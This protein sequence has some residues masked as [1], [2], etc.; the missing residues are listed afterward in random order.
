MDFDNQKF[1][2][3]DL[4]RLDDVLPEQLF[5]IPLKSRP[6]FPGILTP[7]MISMGR[8]SQIVDKTVGTDS[9]VALLLM[10]D[11]DMEDVHK[12]D[13]YEYGTMAR[14]HKKI[15]LPD[16]GIN[17]L[18]NCL[19]RI[20]V[21]EFLS[22]APSINIQVEYLG[23]KLPK[24]DV[25]IKAL[26]RAILSQLKIL[27]ENNPLF[28][29]EMKLTMVNVD[30]PG[31]IADFVASILNL[32][33]KDY[34]YLIEE[35]NVKAR[36]ETV[37]KF[38]EKE[39]DIVE[40]QKR[41][42]GQINEKIE[43]QQ[44]DFFLQEQLKAIRKELGLDEREKNSEVRRLK[45]KLESLDLTEEARERVN[46]ELE[47]L[48]YLE[49]QASDYAVIRN[50]L[51]IVAQL[52]W[53]Q[54]T[55][56]IRDINYAE[57]VLNK[58]HYGLDDVKQRILEFLA[59][60]ILKEDAQGSIICLVGPPGVGKTSLGKSMARALGRE[61][62]RLS[63]GGMRDEAEIKGHRRTYVGA[64]PGKI[65]QGLKLAQSDNPVFMMDEIDK[66]GVSFQ[67]DPASAL[68]EVLD[69]E[70]NSQFRDN[71]LDLSFDISKILFI[72]TAN[73]LDTIPSVLLDRME[74][75][76]LPGYLDDEKYEIFR[77]YLLPKQLKKHALKKQDLKLSKSI[78]MYII[79]RYAR[80]AGLRNLERQVEKLCRHRA[81][82]KV[83]QSD[84][85]KEIKA[86]DLFALL[87]PERF[88]EDKAPHKKV[89][90]L[91]TGLAWTQYG[92]ATLNIEA[93][94]LN[95]EKPLISLTGQL[96]EVMKES[97]N[98]A[99][100]YVQ[101]ICEQ[102][103]G[104]RGFFDKKNI[105]LHIPAGATPKDGPSAGIT[106]ALALLSLATKEAVPR[107]IAMTGELTL[108]GEIFPIGGLK[109]K[110]LAA[111]RNR[112]KTILFPRDNEKDLRDVPEHIKGKIEF[113]PVASFEEVLR[114]CLPKVHKQWHSN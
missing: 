30:D 4:V 70:Q 89:P 10:K 59:V 11:D 34:Q 111:R 2:E 54:S 48:E 82:Q 9:F 26:T 5:V 46:E 75:I 52:P 58:D 61:F 68:L 102:L 6:I 93:I 105:H 100:S 66:L 67:G 33:K 36:L 62:Y 14:V 19:R 49:P 109:E 37:L 21:K 57:D 113:V 22:D 13:L 18:I 29:E 28:T 60:R 45:E 3:S 69:P 91:V 81:Y 85:Q 78:V 8:F 108:T 53:N 90:G 92:G 17:I 41:I 97:A 74:V 23:D 84:Y 42:Q 114:I 47:K 71:Y 94:S 110:T 44:R 112:I 56:D 87:G 107:H 55:K 27:S 63:L 35:T 86:D 25:E 12:T 51:E 101:M 1:S 76:R 65:L 79:D 95:H 72:T 77:R 38:L 20:K 7:L 98:I 39:I 83:R 104:C 24:K 96:G 73:T 43:N 80:E 40:V 32:E 31:R 99:Y 64:M 15:N 106:M 50:Y 16:G 88:V 103:S